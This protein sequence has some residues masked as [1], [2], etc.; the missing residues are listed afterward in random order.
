VD[1][2]EGKL[3]YEPGH[4]DAD[5]NGYVRYPNVDPTQEM[6]DLL[7]ARRLYEANLTVLQSAKQMLR[8]ALD[9]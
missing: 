3:A 2:R 7:D 1:T 5:A 4:P 8:Q 9:I 6:V